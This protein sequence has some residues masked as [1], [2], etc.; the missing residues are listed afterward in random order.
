MIRKSPEF[1]KRSEG[2][3][4]IWECSLEEFA[5]KVIPEV[6]KQSKINHLH[7]KVI[8]LGCSFLRT[9][10]DHKELKGTI[11]YEVSRALDEALVYYVN[12]KGE[13]L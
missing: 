4:E 11:E 13:D 12:G 2:Y 5:N 8:K 1:R 7:T 6:L 9:R 3:P 10:Y